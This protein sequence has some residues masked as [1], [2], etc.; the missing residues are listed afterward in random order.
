MSKQIVS[1]RIDK[2]FCKDLGQPDQY[3]NQYAV[4]LSID[5]QWYG[6]GRKK[7]PVASVKVGQNWHQ[8]QEGDVIEA[9]AEARESGGRTY[10]NMK[11]GDITLKQAGAGGSSSVPS[12]G[13]FVPNKGGGFNDDRQAMIMRQSAMGYAAQIVAATLS[14]KSDI[15]SAATEVIRIANSYFVPF[16]EK[17]IPK[18]EETVVAKAETSAALADDGFKEDDDI[19][20]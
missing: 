18:E 12:K 3:G 8:L 17:G 19:P 15:D 7:K 16:A 2:L 5:G 13:T 10:M 11:S 6:L 1:G 9:V 14:S 4:S 20:F